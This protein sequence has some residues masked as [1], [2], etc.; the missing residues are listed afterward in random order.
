MALQGEE[1]KDD[2]RKALPQE[3]VQE[4]SRVSLWR[5]AARWSRSRCISG[6]G[7]R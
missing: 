7:G 4:L 5:S 1:F 2:F 3:L 6:P